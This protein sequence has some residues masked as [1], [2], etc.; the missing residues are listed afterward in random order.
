MGEPAP[1]PEE[2]SA[3]TPQANH[4]LKKCPEKCPDVV[5][6]STLGSLYWSTWLN[7]E[8]ET[9][10]RKWYA[11]TL[12]GSGML[13]IRTAPGW[14]FGM[15]EVDIIVVNVE[16]PGEPVTVF[17]ANEIIK[18]QT[19]D[20]L[21]KYIPEPVPAVE[22]STA[23]S[24]GPA[25]AVSFDRLALTATSEISAA[26]NP[27]EES[28]PKDEVEAPF[29]ATRSPKVRPMLTQQQK[30]DMTPSAIKNYNRGRKREL[31]KKAQW[32]QS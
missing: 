23:S 17:T 3:A 14:T 13:S 12:K 1:A 24:V 6:A 31:A 2:G 8:G 10:G 32:E 4:G 9:L 11:M 15:D 18:F 19:I 20:E 26:S 28:V 5:L 29:A 25:L 16:R 7:F 30:A 22:V 27:P 21:V